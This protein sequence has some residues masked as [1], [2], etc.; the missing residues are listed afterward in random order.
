MSQNRKSQPQITMYGNIRA[1]AASQQTLSKSRPTENSFVVTTTPLSPTTNTTTTSQMSTVVTTATTQSSVETSVSSVGRV[2]TTSAHAPPCTST[3]QNTSPRMSPRMSPRSMEDNK[4]AQYGETMD[5]IAS[6]RSYEFSQGGTHHGLEYGMNNPKKRTRHTTSP[7]ATPSEIM[8]ILETSPEKSLQNNNLASIQGMFTTI[9]ANHT[10]T[11]DAISTL[12]RKVEAMEDHSKQNKRHEARIAQLESKTGQ[13]NREITAM[14]Q[15]D[16]AK[17]NHERRKDILIHGMSEKYLGK[18]FTDSVEAVLEILE[19]TDYD[20][21]T[22]KGPKGDDE[23]YKRPVKVTL[24]RERDKLTAIK[25]RRKLKDNKHDFLGDKLTV[26]D[27]VSEQTL[28]EHHILQSIAQQLND[29][30]HFAFIPNML[31]R[32]I[33]YKLGPIIDRND[34]STPLKKY[35]IHDYYAGK[36]IPNLPGSIYMNREKPL[37]LPNGEG[38]VFLG[39]QH[40]LSNFNN[41]GPFDLYD[42]KWDMVER[43]LGVD[44]AKKAGDQKSEDIIRSLQNPHH[45]KSQFR[46]IIWK[47]M[48]RGDYDM[49]GIMK[50]AHYAKF[51]QNDKLKEYLLSTGEVPIYEGTRSK[52]WGIGY[53]LSRDTGKIL[54]KANWTNDYQNLCGKSIMMAREKIRNEEM[55]EYY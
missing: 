21:A 4:D 44:Q 38:I 17:I 5:G 50:E 12:T 33:H 14:Q 11:M 35:T 30:N 1:P 24:M 45:I 34:R 6:Q 13:M 8:S 41:E 31:P 25:N 48:N 20:I 40:V 2:S 26:T 28:R 39:K 22:R 46:K 37:E 16:A 55:E 36:T 53:D 29:Q 10:T 49:E 42:E 9:M 18:D 32:Q 15:N 3:I 47:D 51:S 7:S 27:H 54:D 19:I 43:L 23:E 52:K